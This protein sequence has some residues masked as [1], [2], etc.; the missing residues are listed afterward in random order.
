MHRVSNYQKNAAECRL[1]AMRAAT[2]EER[3]Q[4]IAIAE[5]WD[6]LAVER[7]RQAAVD[8]EIFQLSEI[9]RIGHPKSGDSE[10]D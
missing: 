2:P 10:P 7:Q 5:H 4:F 9:P 8:E 3:L 1:L 6:A